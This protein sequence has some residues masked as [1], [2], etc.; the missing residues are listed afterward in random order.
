MSIEADV[1]IQ[2]AEG[3]KTTIYRGTGLA[4]ANMFNVANTGTLT[5]SGVG[6]DTPFVFDGRTKAEAE[7]NTSVDNAAGSTKSIINAAGDLYV[8]NITMQYTKLDVT[9]AQGSTIYTSDATKVLSI[10]DS[11]FLENH[12]SHRGGALYSK[13][14]TKDDAILISGCTFENNTAVNAGGA[15]L[16]EGVTTINIG[17][18]TF[19]GN[20][21]GYFGGAIGT[22]GSKATVNLSGEVLFENNIAH[23]S[24]TLTGTLGGGAISTGKA[25]NIADNASVSIT[26]NNVE[27]IGIGGGVYFQGGSKPVF[28][29]GDG[30]TLLMSGNTDKNGNCD[31]AI[32]SGTIAEGE[33]FVYGNN[34][35]QTISKVMVGDT[36]YNVDAN[37]YLTRIVELRS[38][39]TTTKYAS[40]QEAMEKAID[41]DTIVLLDNITLDSK[42]TIDKS[43][44]ITTDGEADRTINCKAT[45]SLLTVDNADVTLTLK[46]ASEDSKL[47]FDG[48]DVT[49]TESV[50]KIE[51]ANKR[52][53][54]YVTMQNLEG[55][56]EGGNAIRS[57]ALVE[58]E[59][60]TFI[61]CK[62][63]GTGK[64]GGALSLQTNAK[65]STLTNCIFQNCSTTK[66]GG[67]IYTTVGITV[68]GCR[69]TGC[70][71]T[72]TR[73][74]AICGDGCGAEGILIDNC[75][76]GDGTTA[77]AN[78]AKTGGGAVAAV[79]QQTLTI[80]NSTF[81]G[82]EATA[83]FGG[84]V[85]FSTA[86]STLNLEGRCI[87][88][89][90]VGNC[91][92]DY[93]GGALFAPKN[94]NIAE[95]AW[96]EFYGNRNK[97]ETKPHGDAFG[98]NASSAE[99]VNFTIGSGASL[100]V[101]DNPSADD[102]NYDICIQ[103]G[104][105]YIP[106]KGEGT[107]ST[108]A[109]PTTE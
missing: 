105:Q 93:R 20:E 24:T 38:G 100:Y 82:N 23:T 103:K 97:S 7:A 31:I 25:L 33:Q 83:K 81:D 95:N 51:N 5:L 39:E 10:K 70:K 77:G 66:Y 42:V 74:G 106:N 22:S 3:Q 44:T 88:R 30:A 86:A 12:S 72:E 55:T 11:T 49:L 78:T 107:Y 108:S 76:F 79:G 48:S 91:D 94:F 6:D 109:P 104:V 29:L 90:N 85:A 28:T 37:G 102:G 56:T 13:E 14:K 63:P 52:V 40:I 32:A 75:T 96:I 84:A 64:N 47:I 54:Q 26:N 50:V 8:E 92:N 1:T 71:A 36:T 101:Y 73:G 65:G 53:M 2:N 57:F 69:F 34:K 59:D 60:C 89:N 21:A 43:V 15:V 45:T 87:F 18:C 35:N 67:A 46:G 68:T 58:A 16:V 19:K 62:L 99:D 17:D 80:K 98:F 61:N 27:Q 41:G 9:D 4:S